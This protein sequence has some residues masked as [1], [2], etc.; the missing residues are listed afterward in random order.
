MRLEEKIPPQDLLRLSELALGFFKVKVDVQRRNKVGNGVAVFVQ[1]LLH[2]PDEV[3]ELLWVLAAV[4][5]I[6]IAVGDD[7]RSEVAEDPRARGLDC[8]DECWGEEEV[9][10]R[11]LGSVVVEQGKERPVD[12]PR[13]VLQLGQRVIIKLFPPQMSGLGIHKMG[14]RF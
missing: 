11:V 9:Q 8:V 5:A 7:R 2:D 4:V 6:A 14:W 10:E 3:F 13:P 12:Q 1:L